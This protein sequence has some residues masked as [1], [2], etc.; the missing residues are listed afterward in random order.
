MSFAF[1]SFFIIHPS[2]FI[3]SGQPLTASFGW[4]FGGNGA[5][6]HAGNCDDGKGT[7]KDYVATLPNMKTMILLHRMNAT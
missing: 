7:S 1:T 3:H 2:T 4:V 6:N 5:L